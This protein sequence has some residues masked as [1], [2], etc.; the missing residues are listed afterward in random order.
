MVGALKGLQAL[1]APVEHPVIML[2]DSTYLIRGITM[3]IWGWRKR[4]WRNA[5]GAEVQNRD[6]WEEL[7]AQLNRLKPLDIS[8]Q[9]VRGHIGVPG[10]ERCD[11]I[12]VSYSKGKKVPLFSGP[13]LKYPYAIHD[14]PDP[15]PLPEMKTYE[16]KPPA[17]SYL[18]MQGGTVMRHATWAE[19][20][21][22]VKGQSGAKFKKAQSAS[23][24]A[25]ILKS[26]GLDPAKTPIK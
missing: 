5:S 15:E 20:E 14:L 11:E 12:A 24:E 7:A 23:D 4:G 18:S 3:W 17:H 22:R 9:Y 26:W 2:T 13:L 21:R 16:K 6:V 8:W 19:C 1:E 25:A 10:N